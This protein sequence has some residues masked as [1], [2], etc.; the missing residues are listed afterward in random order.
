[1]NILTVNLV[2]STLIFWIAAKLY[3]LPRI[4]ELEPRTILLPIL[5]LHSLR[6]LG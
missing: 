6:H 5:L 4:T 2:L 1:M 3:L